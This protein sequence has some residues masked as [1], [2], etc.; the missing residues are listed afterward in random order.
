MDKARARIE[1]IFSTKWANI[2]LGRTQSKSEELFETCHISGSTVRGSRKIRDEAPVR[3]RMGY[4]FA[5]L[6][7]TNATISKPSICQCPEDTS[8]APTIQHK[9]LWI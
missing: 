5:Q 2:G 6:H 9:S 8:E 1:A 3:L 7:G 4:T